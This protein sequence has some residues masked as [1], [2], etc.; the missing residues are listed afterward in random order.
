ML[1]ITRQ[2]DAVFTNQEGGKRHGF[3]VEVEVSHAKND[4]ISAFRVEPKLLYSN[5][6]A[7]FVSHDGSSTPLFEI[8]AKNVVQNTH[9]FRFRINEV[10][11]RHNGNDFCIA[12]TCFKGQE[13]VDVAYSNPVRVISRTPKRKRTKKTS[14]SNASAKIKLQVMQEDVS[15]N[16]TQHALFFLRELGQK[17]QLEPE[18]QRRLSIL[19][20]N[21]PNTDSIGGQMDNLTRDT[22]VPTSEFASLS[23]DTDPFLADLDVALGTSDDFYEPVISPANTVLSPLSD[24]LH[25]HNI[26]SPCNSVVSLIGDTTQT[27]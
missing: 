8:L 22:Q 20:A 5:L 4:N 16:W 23:I 27:L 25:H 21:P 12:L 18:M 3:C 11:R 6:Q 7:P 19:L 13:Q 26:L 9:G 2:P 15:C 14:T 1:T 24:L 17:Q 10:S